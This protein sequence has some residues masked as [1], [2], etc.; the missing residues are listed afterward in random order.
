MLWGDP[1]S[2]LIKGFL[3]TTI[4]LNQMSIAASQLDASQ[5]TPPTKLSDY[6]DPQEDWKSLS[7]ICKDSGMQVASCTRPALLLIIISLQ[8]LLLCLHP[9]CN[10]PPKKKKMNKSVT[11]ATKCK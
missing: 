5:T 3:G 1:Y 4:A 11:P 10:P 8:H 6:Y 2:D 7:M 9:C